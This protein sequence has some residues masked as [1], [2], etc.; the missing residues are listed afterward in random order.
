MSNVATRSTRVARSMQLNGD[1]GVKTNLHHV[2]FHCVFSQAAK[3]NCKLSTVSLPGKLKASYVHVANC[4]CR[5][6]S[7][8]VFA[9]DE[10][11]KHPPKQN[12]CSRHCAASQT[13][14]ACVGRKRSSICVL[15][16][17][18]GGEKACR[19]IFYKHPGIKDGFLPSPP[20]QVGFQGLS[21]VSRLISLRNH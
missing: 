15:Q 9:V 2:W 19:I 3:K 13:T 14:V 21:L 11:A 6:M 8:R 16:T 18:A 10:L 20:R 4:V 17:S 7:G 5:G 1:R 12:L